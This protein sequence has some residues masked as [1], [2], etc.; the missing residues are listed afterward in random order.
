VFENGL[1]HDRFMLEQAGG[2]VN[3]WG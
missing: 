2:I 3:G 1:I